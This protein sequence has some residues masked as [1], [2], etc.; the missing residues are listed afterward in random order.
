LGTVKLV[1]ILV[2]RVTDS[3]LLSFQYTDF[4][5]PHFLT[6]PIFMTKKVVAW[7][8]WIHLIRLIGNIQGSSNLWLN[9]LTI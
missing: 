4:N 2:T 1:I 9:N 8:K 5:S 6:I 3:A 7:Q